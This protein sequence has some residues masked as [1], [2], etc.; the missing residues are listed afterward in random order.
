VRRLITALALGLGLLGCSLIRE[1]VPSGQSI[2]LD[3]TGLSCNDKPNWL[4]G[5]LTAHVEVVDPLLGGT[6]LAVT[7]IRIRRVD[8]A[9]QVDP[10]PA[11]FRVPVVPVTWPAAY[12]GVLM[13][14]RQV[15]VVDGSGNLVAMTG[16]E[17]RLTGAVLVIAAVGG[18]LFGKGGWVHSV[19]VCPLAGSVVQQ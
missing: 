12:T 16:R 11:G 1:P 3:H 9:L 13:A 2:E 6:D 7:A 17:Y 19:T 5:S 14:D 15:A 8:P 10:D 4:E 18:E